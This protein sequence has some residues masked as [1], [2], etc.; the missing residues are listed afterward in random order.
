MK[1]PPV[2][3][4]LTDIGLASRIPSKESGIWAIPRLTGLGE[5][6]VTDLS[7][8][9]V[10]ER[11]LC[12]ATDLRIATVPPNVVG[13][14]VIFRGTSNHWK[15]LVTLAL[16][17]ADETLHQFAGKGSGHLLGRDGIRMPEPCTPLAQPTT[18][19]RVAG[20]GPDR[21][22]RSEGLLGLLESL[23]RGP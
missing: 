21:G 6:Y 10:L 3:A 9:S 15:P 14:L 13:C 5:L 23:L 16:S 8:H 4:A 2:P 11:K 20:G 17:S 18:G 7:G 1:N 22:L 19:P 12:Q